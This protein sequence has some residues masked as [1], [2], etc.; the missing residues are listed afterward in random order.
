M[1]NCRLYPS[2]AHIRCLSTAHFRSTQEM[3]ER[4]PVPLPPLGEA[5]REDFLNF[6]YAGIYTFMSFTRNGKTR[7]LYMV[8]CFYSVN[9][10]GNYVC[11]FFILIFLG[12]KGSPFMAAINGYKFEFPTCPPQ[13]IYFFSLLFSIT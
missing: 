10:F 13:V 12:F 1:H 4:Q 6:H 9:K 3:I 7:K 8:V 11:G 2:D 5:I